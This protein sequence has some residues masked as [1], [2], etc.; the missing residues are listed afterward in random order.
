MDEDPHNPDAAAFDLRHWLNRSTIP[1]EQQRIF[2][3][4]VSMTTDDIVAAFDT[5]GG[6]SFNEMVP[7][8]NRS[9]L[10]SESDQFAFI[11]PQFATEN[12][13]VDLLWLGSSEQRIRGKRPWADGFGSRSVRYARLSTEGR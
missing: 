4:R 10:R 3:H 5:F 12:G 2:L 6:M 8:R 1:T 9:L 11:C 13:G 7:F